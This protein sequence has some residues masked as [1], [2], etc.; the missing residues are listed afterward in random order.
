MDRS[1]SIAVFSDSALPILNGVAV[2]VNLLVEELRRRGHFVVL[3]T[4]AFPGFEDSDPDTVRFPSVR[5]KE[6]PGYPLAVPPFVAF[7]PAFK[8]HDFDIVHTHTP[9]TVGYAGLKWAQRSGIPIVST[10]HTQY[11]RYTHYFPYAPPSVVRQ[12]IRRHTKLYY[13]QVDRIL[14][15]SNF[16]R[17]W[18]RKQQVTRPI[19]VV[20]TGIPQ[21]TDLNQSESRKQLRFSDDQVVMLYVGRLAREKNIPTLLDA[22]AQAVRE[23]P[24]ILLCLVG[25]GPIRAEMEGYAKDLGIGNHIRFEGSK[26]RTEV[27]TYYAAADVFTFASQS[28]TQGLVVAEAMSYGMPAIVVQ[29]GGASEA[30]EDGQN[31]FI[32]PSSAMHIAQRMIRVAN[33]PQ[34]RVS[35]GNNAKASIYRFTIEGMGDAVLQNYASALGQNLPVRRIASVI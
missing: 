32:S 27:D 15:P 1:L 17:K 4:S 33:D 5:V 16:S 29:G 12:Q 34:E 2:S 3:Y 25:D 13:N 35:L 10:Y 14:T 7:L 31:G 6:H 24:N 20:P 11:D 19:E 26:P 22:T 28:E 30:V 18:L 23:N 8:R 21:P 9:F